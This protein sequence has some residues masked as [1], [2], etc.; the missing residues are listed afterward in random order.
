MEYNREFRKIYFEY[1]DLEGLLV[2]IG[3]QGFG[4]ILFVVQ[5]CKKILECYF[6]VF[7]CFNVVIK[8][9]E[10][11]MILYEGIWFLSCLQNGYGGVLYLIDEIYLEWNSF[12]SKN[13]FVEEM[14]EFVQQRK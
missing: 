4:K 7:F 6:V 8:G 9:L 2:F 1:F 5:Y 10:E 14:M 12:E 3:L 11:R 13:I